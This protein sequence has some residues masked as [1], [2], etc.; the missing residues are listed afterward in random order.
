MRSVVSKRWPTRPLSLNLL[1][2]E[3]D[4]FETRSVILSRREQLCEA[5]RSVFLWRNHTRKRIER[6][7][8][9]ERGSDGK[10]ESICCS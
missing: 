5:G 2:S 9:K 4:R 1:G 6:A 7:F 10:P 8:I 3:E